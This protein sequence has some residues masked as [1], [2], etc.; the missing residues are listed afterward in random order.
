MILDTTVA[1]ASEEVAT[2]EGQV[3]RLNIACGRG[4]ETHTT[5]IQ[6]ALW[7]RELILH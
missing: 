7:R 6:N 3:E 4:R 2:T 1:A 5:L